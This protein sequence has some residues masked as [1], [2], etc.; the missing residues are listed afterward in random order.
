MN[1][2][3]QV[4]TRLNPGM[5]Y[6]TAH[7][8][9]FIS[10]DGEPHTLIPQDET[11]IVSGNQPGGTRHVFTDAFDCL[12]HLVQIAPPFLILSQPTP[13]QP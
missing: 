2:F 6:D 10:K 7:Y 12:Q 9:Y 4:I 3:Q 1:K 8:L 11:L 13:L 5:V